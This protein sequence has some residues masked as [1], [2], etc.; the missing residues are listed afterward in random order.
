MFFYE[1]HEG[2]EDV[3]TAVLLGHEERFDPDD[4][5]ALVKKVRKLLGDTYEEDTLSE[6][7]AN[8]LQR[9]HGFLHVTDD[10]LVASVSVGETDADTYL[11]TQGEDARTIFVKGEDNGHAGHDHDEDEDEDEEHQN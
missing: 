10:L 7:I 2:D 1:I 9:S 6:A 5:F 8:E 4:F 11:V 3:G